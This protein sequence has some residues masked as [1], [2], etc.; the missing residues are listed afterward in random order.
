MALTLLLDWVCQ[1]CLQ[2]WPDTNGPGV[3]QLECACVLMP[4]VAPSAFRHGIM[5]EV[6]ADIVAMAKQMEARSMQ[7]P[8]GMHQELNRFQL[9]TAALMLL[10]PQQP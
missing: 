9:R 2:Q 8:Q 5:R 6:F 3:S 1:V 7:V 10:V 4:G